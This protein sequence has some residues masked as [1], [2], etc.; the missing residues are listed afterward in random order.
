[1][2][3]QLTVI[4]RLSS[5]SGPLWPAVAKLKQRWMNSD[6]ARDQAKEAA[7]H[8]ANEF[9]TMMQKWN[10]QRWSCWSL[11]FWCLTNP[12]TVGNQLLATEMVNAKASGF[13]HNIQK[14]SRVHHRCG[15][16]QR[17]WHRGNRAK[18]VLIGKWCSGWTPVHFIILWSLH[19]QFEAGGYLHC[20]QGTKLL[21]MHNFWCWWT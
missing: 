10:G 1:M 16:S 14:Q 9:L 8:T 17:L 20:A 2:A 6:L 3:L 13:G 12:K 5:A 21:P 4:R 18:T 7:V 11:A 15:G 19:V